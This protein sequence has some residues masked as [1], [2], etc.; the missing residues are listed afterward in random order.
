MALTRV[1]ALMVILFFTLLLS[2]AVSSKDLPHEESLVRDHNELRRSTEP[3]AANMNELVSQWFVH[4]T[5]FN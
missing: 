4:K 3:S 2:G 5:L 1:V